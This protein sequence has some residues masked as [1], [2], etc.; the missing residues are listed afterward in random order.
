MKNAVK[1]VFAIIVLIAALLVA[2]KMK[3]HREPF[4]PMP[5]AM[6]SNPAFV[7]TI[8]PTKKKVI[9]TP[10]LRGDLAAF[11]TAIGKY[12]SGNNPEVVNETNH[13]GKYQFHP[14][15]LAVL[16]INTTKDSF[17]SNPALQDSAMIKYMK[18]NFAALRPIISQFAGKWHNGVYVT[19]SGI[20]AGAHLVGSGGMKTYFYPD[21]YAYATSDHNGATA[22]Y[23]L[24]KFSNYAIN[25][26]YDL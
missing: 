22:E 12:E 10:M 16:G 11:M 15:T 7:D 19:V 17:L 2:P 4:D 26:R 3:V 8:V 21:K 14:H 9:R 5:P 1:T 18:L 13:M 6:H 24:K 20:L 25:L 23:Y